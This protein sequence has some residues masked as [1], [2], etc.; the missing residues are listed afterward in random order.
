MLQANSHT[1]P[2]NVW[3][4]RITKKKESDRCDLYKDLWITMLVTDPWRAG[5]GRS[6]RMEV[7]VY[8]GREMPP[9]V[10]E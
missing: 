8:V 2:S 7:L 4:H 6:S 9:D 3:I 1:F 5:T 10:M